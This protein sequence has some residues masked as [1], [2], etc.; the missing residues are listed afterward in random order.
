MCDAVLV[1]VVCGV[2]LFLM[3]TVE[4]ASNR[5]FSV[6]T[7]FCGVNEPHIL[8]MRDDISLDNSVASF[9]LVQLHTTQHKPHTLHDTKYQ[10]H[11]TT[12]QSGSLT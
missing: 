12:Q 6:E 3:N 4:I 8:E 5:A 9:C 7:K 2:T 10:Q 11:R 1:C